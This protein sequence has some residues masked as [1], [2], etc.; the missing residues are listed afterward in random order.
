MRQY[1][2]RARHWVKN[3]DDAMEI[4][5]TPAFIDNVLKDMSQ[6]VWQ[7][8]ATVSHLF[9][10]GHSDKR[11]HGGESAR[12]LRRKVPSLHR[13]CEQRSGRRLSPHL[14]QQYETDDEDEEA[15]EGK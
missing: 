4:E 10:P 15:D 11:P 1:P 14:L 2:E 7:K 13:Q 5:V 9:R 3:I 6:E 12:S 8:S